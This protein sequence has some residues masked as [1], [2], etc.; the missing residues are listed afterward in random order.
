M[1]LEI[2]RYADMQR[3]TLACKISG[4]GFKLKA[5]CSN[6]TA[7]DSLTENKRA[8]FG[9]AVYFYEIVCVTKL[10]KLTQRSYS[11]PSSFIIIEAA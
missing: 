7:N 9:I 3:E 8:D 5:K 6:Y 4:L 1:S 2:V 11:N 10:Q